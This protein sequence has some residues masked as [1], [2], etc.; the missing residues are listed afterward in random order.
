MDLSGG[1]KRK[2]SPVM[3]IINDPELLVLDE[4]NVGLDPES[5]RDVWGLLIGMKRGGKSII[6]T[7]HYLNEAR[8]AQRQDILREQEGP[9]LGDP[10]EI[11]SKS[12]SWY[13]V[14]DYSEGKVYRVSREEV[15]KLL[16]NI[17][18]DFEVRKPSLEDVYLEV[19][20]GK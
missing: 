9:A 3:T 7:T 18:G 20:R 12:S 11:K 4:L 10:S 5:R 1:M 17:R 19:S 15:K 6:I 2:L 13:E 8:E 14:I 16:A